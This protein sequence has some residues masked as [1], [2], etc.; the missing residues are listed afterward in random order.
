MYRGHL[1][2]AAS[3]LAF[4]P[5][6]VEAKAEI[7]TPMGDDIIVSGR[8]EK[9]YRVTD[10]EIGRIAADPLDIPQSVQVLTA[11]LIRDQGAR[12]ITDLY[13]NV[14]GVTENQ[15]ATVTYRGFRQDG[16]FYDGLRGDPFQS[17]SVPSLFGVERVEF[18]KGPVGML[19]GASAPGGMINYVTKKPADDFGAS[20]RLIAGNYDRV[21]ASGE[22]TGPIDANGI[23]AARIGAFYETYDTVQR[24]T[25]NETTMLDG[26]L[27]IHIAPDTKLVT[28]VTRF[29]QDLPGNR[30]RGIP[31][32]ADGKFLARRSWNHNEA[33]DF[34]KLNGTVVQSRL[35]HRFS[36]AVSLNAATRW[37]RYKEDQDFHDPVGRLDTDGDGVVDAISR[38]FRRQKRDIEGL[39]VSGN[40][41]ARFTT[42]AIEHSFSA[43]GDW[44]WQNSWFLG[45]RTRV[46]VPN[47]SLRNPVYAVRPTS[48]Y[49]LTTG[50]RDLTDTTAHRY[51]VYAQHQ[52]EVDRFILVGG[53]RQ[54]WFDDRDA[55]DPKTKGDR[56]SW[57]VGTVFKPMPSAS[58][59]ASYAQSFEP[60]DPGSQSRDVGGPFAPVASR[61]VEVGAKGSLLGGKLQPTIALYH[62]VRD[63]IVQ[64][65]PSAPPVNGFDQLRPVGEVTS[66]GVEF[67]L[68]ADM[69]PDWVVT[70]NYAY[71]DAKI[72]GGVDGQVIDSSFGKR[73][74]NAP[75][76]QAGAWSRYQV[77]DLD[78]GVALGGRYVSRQADR[79]GNWI[80]SYAIFDGSLTKGLGFADVM[81][82][83]ENIFD[84]TYALSA[85]DEIRGAFVGRPRTVFIELRRDF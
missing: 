65:D 44:Y 64:A 29:R 16:I 18:L 79:R 68:A 15:Y 19:Y 12:D 2:L 75:R 1:F 33:T 41:A 58:L 73:F 5:A 49:D 50:R 81:L 60:Q 76:H 52:I 42:G 39:T 37:F 32:G 21:G 17:F 4:T 82:R 46:G 77:R 26:G 38:E 47:L 3:A 27:T 22:I 40:L 78:L 35:D 10:T 80:K 62:I 74:P 54:D 20:L 25:R 6:P 83:V 30:L 45:Q 11:D 84:K 36:D 9:L 61:Q 69:T 7:E 57:R 24:F 53:L 48:S 28:Q 70:A 51:G 8:A 14:A 13:R 55:G 31:T 67:T 71:N 59:Y 43:G 72:T 85:L 23:V 66:K 63:N 34:T 56:L